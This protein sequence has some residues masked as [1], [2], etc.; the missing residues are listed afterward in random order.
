MD[1]RRAS[2][3]MALGTLVSRVIGFLGMIL[4]TYATG[5]IGSGANA[6][7]VANYL[8]N[9]IYAIV[10]GG[11]VNAVLIPQVVRFSA[12]GNERYIN[13]ITT[14]A[15]VLFAFITL[16]AAFLS[17]TLVK[18]TAG[19]G[20]D[21]QTTAVAI[22]FAYWCV[23][24]IFFYAIYSVLGEVLN[25]RK[26]YGPFTWTPAINNIV[27]ISGILLFILVFGA[28][29]EGSRGVWPPFAIAILGGSATLGIA[30]Q[31]LFLLIFWKSAGLRFKPDFNWRGIQITNLGKIFSWTF[32]MV[33]ITTIAGLVETNISTLAGNHN[34]S[35]AVMQRA[36]LLFML[37][38]SLVTVSIMTPYFTKLSEKAVDKDMH[39]YRTSLSEVIRIVCLALVGGTAVLMVSAFPLA[40]IFATQEHVVHSMAL[41]II[42]YSLG[43]VAFSTLYILQ[44][45]FYALCDTRTPFFLA[46]ICSG[47][48]IIGALLCA[49]LPA[50]YIAPGLA[51]TVSLSSVLQCALA[52]WAIRVKLG[53]FSVREIGQK[54][55]RYT[56][57]G[58]LASLVGI[59]VAVGLTGFFFQNP[60][61]SIITVVMIALVMLPIYSYFLVIT[62][63]QEIRFFFK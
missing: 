11:T 31:A 45:A 30:C 23:P 39:G 62:R 26:V 42:A 1:T 21:K 25:A 47:V 40:R 60:V 10:A 4:L 41:T 57:S 63:C 20:F 37:P 14:L 16:V 8:P 22:S 34:A 55:A 3:V 50:E 54:F 46:A 19:A 52:F 33:V 59:G 15:I 2:A 12:S 43:L 7:A 44:K 35:V 18:I 49:L 5:S 36:W 9:M 53:G 56:L 29:P 24:Q 6:F 17:P 48:I 13:K 38:H 58:L 28:D 27:F 61:N 51:L 32:F